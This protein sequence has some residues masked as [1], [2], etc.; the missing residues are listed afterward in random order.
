MTE[1]IPPSFSVVIPCRNEEANVANMAAAVIREMEAI[2][3]AF[4]LIFI[5]NDS[6][7]DTRAIV[8]GLC[9]RDSR[10]RLIENARNFGQMRSPTYAIFQARGQAIINLCC[11][12]QDPPELLPLFVERWRDGAQIVLGVRSAEKSALL[13][14]WFRRFSYW[15]A[16][17]F[18]DYPIIA[19]ATGFGLYA[20][21]VVR[22]IERLNEP[23]PF[24]RG[25]L[26]E[27]GFRTETIAYPR[28]PRAGG[29]SNNGFFQLLDFAMSSLAGASKRMVRVPFFI[30]AT[31]LIVAAVALL[32]LPVA[33]LMGQGNW[34]IGLGAIALVEAHTGLLFLFLGILG[35][36]VRLISERTRRTP[37][38]VER[39]RVNFPPDY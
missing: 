22:V 19:N 34:V 33:W 16:T 31:M 37:L 13:L 23:E 26:V 7:D 2:G 29:V 6:L 36:Q 27:T 12:F 3:D 14:G 10:I 18:G 8:R 28:P 25:M 30:G 11:D 15:F 1:F 38:V 32:C 24:F 21:K 35:D 20:N 39:D 9:A 5:D 4:D 17:R